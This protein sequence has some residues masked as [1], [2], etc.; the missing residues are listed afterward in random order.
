MERIFGVFKREFGVFKTAPKYP[1]DMQA[2]FVPA[3][4]AVHNFVSVHDRDRYNSY[5]P[6]PP[7]GSQEGGPSAAETI[8]E[9]GVITEEELGFNITAE[10]RQRAIERRDQIARQMWVDYQAEL[11]RRGE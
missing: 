7:T 6:D 10:E 8:P 1:M 9:T 11:R 4:G 2:M 3:L 5:R